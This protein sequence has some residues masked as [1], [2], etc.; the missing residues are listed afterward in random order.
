MAADGTSARADLPAVRRAGTRRSS[1][2]TCR[3]SFRRGGWP[4]ARGW[5]S[6]ESR[7][8]PTSACATCRL[9]R[10]ASEAFSRG[11]D[12]RAASA[13]SSGTATIAGRA[14]S[15]R[16]HGTASPSDQPSPATSMSVDVFVR[17]MKAVP[18]LEKVGVE[19]RA[20]ARSLT[21]VSSDTPIR[22]SRRT[23]E[24]RTT[25]KALKDPTLYARTGNQSS[26]W[27]GSRADDPTRTRAGSTSGRCSMT[28]LQGTERRHVPAPSSSARRSSLSRAR[29][30]SRPTLSLGRSTS[31]AE[32]TK[33]SRATSVL[34]SFASSFRFAK[35][36]R[37]QRATSTP[38]CPHQPLDRDV[39]GR[40]ALREVR[41]HRRT[42]SRS[43]SAGR[44]RPMTRRG[45]AKR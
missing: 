30:H 8:S 1:R 41:H 36:P 32:A 21:C 12:S 3:W 26:G 43:S 19:G 11:E 22:A 16:I 27:D 10:S 7:C 39:D 28:P 44:A 40:E 25:S 14:K 17:A 18:I 2:A 23:F 37:T 13:T 6:S 4:V 33:L 5:T 20:N 38:S 15:R 29:M 45:A 34:G 42:R 35:S 9:S 24:A 31:R